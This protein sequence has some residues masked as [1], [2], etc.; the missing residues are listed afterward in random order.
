MQKQLLEFQLRQLIRL[1]E[2]NPEMS[3]NNMHY[4]IFS[5]YPSGLF[6]R[7]IT[8]I[9]IDMSEFKLVKIL[10]LEMQNVISTK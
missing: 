3:F 2:I 6:L 10:F 8:D 4:I 9:A 1:I 7:Q 5:D